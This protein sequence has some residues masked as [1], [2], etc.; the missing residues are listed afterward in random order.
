MSIVL[1][2]RWRESVG[3]EV[4]GGIGTLRLKVRDDWL[5]IGMKLILSR[6]YND[7]IA[8]TTAFIIVYYFSDSNSGGLVL[9]NLMSYELLSFEFILGKTLLRFV[10][11]S[12]FSWIKDQSIFKLS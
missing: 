12:S 9:I 11:F 1:I 8:K 5:S 4:N 7:T 2:W 10:F 3:F 6:A